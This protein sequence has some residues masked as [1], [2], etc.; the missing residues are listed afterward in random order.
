MSLRAT[1]SFIKQLS[2][3]WP[4]SRSKNRA[5]IRRKS[6]ADR[7]TFAVYADDVLPRVREEVGHGP[8][9]EGCV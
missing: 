2:L 3:L 9:F 1:Y 6:D 8:S 7:A 4:F 5:R